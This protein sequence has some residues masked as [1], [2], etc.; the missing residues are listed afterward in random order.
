MVPAAQSGRR[1][2]PKLPPWE[3]IAQADVPS[4]W[5]EIKRLP[6]APFELISPM[7]MKPKRLL[8]FGSHIIR[9][10]LGLIE[11]EVDGPLTIPRRQRAV[12]K[13]D[14][15][16]GEEIVL[17]DVS[18][19]DSEA[20]EAEDS[21]TTRKCKAAGDDALQP[22]PKRQGGGASA[23]KKRKIQESPLGEEPKVPPAKKQRKSAP[24]TKDNTMNQA[25]AKSSKPAAGVSKAPKKPKQTGAVRKPK[26]AGHKGVPECDVAEDPAQMKHAQSESEEDGFLVRRKLPPAFRGDFLKWRNDF[27]LRQDALDW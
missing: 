2:K 27:T 16:D 23:G 19:S 20:E 6:P 7:L 3:D 26:V 25:S 18:A 11:P 8:E 4:T 21:K 12:P 24:K 22:A 10:E 14:A 15:E 9:G 17:D 5:V 13:P 1:K